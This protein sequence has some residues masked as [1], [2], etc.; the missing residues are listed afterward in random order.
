[1]RQVIVDIRFLILKES[2][3]MH[4]YD[5]SKR[6]AVH[7]THTSYRTTRRDRPIKLLA[8]ELFM[9]FLALTCGGLLLVDGLGMPEST[10]ES[11]PF[12]SFLIPGLLLSGVVGG[13][14]LLAARLIWFRRPMAPIMSLLAGII[15][16]CWII[17][18]AIMVHDGRGLQVAV[19]IYALVT[20]AMASGFLRRNPR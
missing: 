5:A 16:L 14:M 20:I 8:V 10:L 4:A 18:E 13:S 3:I 6:P 2:W 19:A 9:G 12:D 1:M 11:S 7:A 17:V 15:L